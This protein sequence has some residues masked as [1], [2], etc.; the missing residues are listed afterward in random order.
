[1]DWLG[2]GT[3]E[4]R[5][6]KAKEGEA[7]TSGGKDGCDEAQGLALKQA[8]AI[9]PF[10]YLTEPHPLF[11]H[12][13]IITFD[14]ADKIINHSLHQSVFNRHREVKVKQAET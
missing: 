6:G 14:I 10:I 11:F 7:E 5:T 3:E 2:A 13:P 4:G 1:M 9:S 12:S 8:I